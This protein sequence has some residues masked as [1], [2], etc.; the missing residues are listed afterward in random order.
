MSVPLV[1][2]V[3][4]TWNRHSL[5]N[6]RCIP[7]VQLQTYPKVEH[8][9]ISDGPDPELMRH[10]RNS[11]PALGN[12]MDIRQGRRH[13]LWYYQLPEHDPAPHWGTYARLM[14][15]EMAA[16]DLIAYC[17]DDDALRPQHCEL[18]ARALEENPDAG[19]AVSLM[20]S[21]RPD[22]GMGEIGHGEPSCGN[23]G[24]PMIVHRREI[25][26]H[27]TWGV[28]S[29]FEDW[30]LTNRWLHA[31]IQYVQVPTVTVDAWP[32]LF[33]GSGHDG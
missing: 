25:L 19:F 17:D 21:H 15:I 1:S 2:V 13:P 16:G 18:L 33:Y 22:S 10:F 5:L 9:I 23:I 3:T 7:S 30:E 29:D 14:G 31:G 28:P 20:G 11:M 26:E 6:D 27:G 32:S 8:V 4:A 12:R 24:T